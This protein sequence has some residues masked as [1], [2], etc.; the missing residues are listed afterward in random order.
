MPDDEPDEWPTAEWNDL[1]NDELEITDL[2]PH[3]RHSRGVQRVGG[4]GG[5]GSRH[6]QRSQWVQR[7]WQWF[8][9][10][11]SL[12]LLF[13]VV[14]VGP[15]SGGAL[16]RAGVTETPAWATSAAMVVNAS[17]T[18]LVALPPTPEPPLAPP[19]PLPGISG[20]TGGSAAAGT[21]EPPLGPAPTSCGEE[22]PALTPGGPPF[23]RWAI[24]REPV[25]LGGFIG[26]YAT[27]PLGRAASTIAY[28][29]TAPYTPYGWPA[30]IGLMVQAGLPSGPVTLSGWDQLTGHPLWF[31]FVVA[32]DWGA[33]QHVVPTFVLDPTH[34]SIPAGGWA[35][36]ETFWY[37]YVFLPGAGCYTLTASWPGGNWRV[38]VS[39][40]SV[41]AG[42]LAR[43]GSM[44]GRP[45][46]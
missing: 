22:L 23:G 1:D 35:S 14:L 6:I 13:A 9:L 19:T 21:H 36:P 3:R 16:W 10:G 45:R 34:P 26:P 7:G 29:W 31:G 17:G 32:G 27:M 12:M 4:V 46:R 41:N 42:Q 37:G 40:G 25:L 18:R 30:P 43:L 8:A 2:R 20:S 39:A 38:T 11:L 24:G 44:V 15:A 33:P 5:I 28:G